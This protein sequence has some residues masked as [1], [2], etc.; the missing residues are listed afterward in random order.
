MKYNKPAL[1][2]P[3]QADLLFKRGLKA[4]LKSTMIYRWI[5]WGS[6]KTGDLSCFGSDF[7]YEGM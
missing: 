6:L 3:Q 5:L 4:C 1:T 7:D 2:F